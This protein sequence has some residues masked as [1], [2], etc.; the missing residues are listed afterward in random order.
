MLNVKAALAVCFTCIGGMS[1]LL[2]KFELPPTAQPSPF[3]APP[4]NVEVVLGLAPVPPVA[5]ASDEAGAWRNELARQFNHPNP[6]E[7]QLAEQR[8]LNLAAAE[9]LQATPVELPPLR[10]P[11]LAHSEEAEA[12]QPV[13]ASADERHAQDRVVLASYSPDATE[14]A[15]GSAA[16]PEM[17]DAPVAVA[18]ALESTLAEPRAAAATDKPI[19]Y[20]V[21]RGDTLTRI[22]ARQ[23]ATDDPRLVQWMLARNNDLRKRNGHVMAGEALTLPSPDQAAQ[24][25]AALDRGDVAVAA[26]ASAFRWYTVQRNDSLARIAR[27]YLQDEGRWHEI[28]E[29][30]RS[31][32]PNRLS[33]GERIRL[34]LVVALQG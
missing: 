16:A 31:L 21:V 24:V 9:L 5:S 34:P 19:T 17:D 13:L 7:A 4:A 26:D 10:L 30:N 29:L 25:L 6:V 15:P 11:P 2:H 3:D 28:L 22:L 23:C 20:T 1:W 14:P 27:R 8:T 12:P 18:P 33:P 32:N